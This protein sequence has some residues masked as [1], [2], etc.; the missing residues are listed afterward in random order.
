MLLIREVRIIDPVTETDQ[1]ADILIEGETIC[2]VGRHL[3]GISA[4]AEEN[5]RTGVRQIK[6]RVM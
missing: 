5:G 2:R 4:E 1:T 6:G 3:E